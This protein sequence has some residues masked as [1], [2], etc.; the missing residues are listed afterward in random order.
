MTKEIIQELRG[1]SRSVH[2]AYPGVDDD[3][4]GEIRDVAASVGVLMLE[5]EPE[6]PREPPVDVD[7]PR[8]PPID[9]E[10]PVGDPG[11]LED[12]HAVFQPGGKFDWL[13]DQYAT[14]LIA[15][16]VPFFDE[17][18]RPD[19][20][21]YLID[22]NYGS[23]VNDVGRLSGVRILGNSRRVNGIALWWTARLYNATGLL[24]GAD[25]V[26]VG[27]FVADKEGH[28][29]VYADVHGNLHIRKTR[30]Y[31][32][33]GQSIQLIRRPANCRMSFDGYSPPPFRPGENE[34]DYNAR[35]SKSTWWK[36]QLYFQRQHTI[37]L[38]DVQSTDDGLGKSRGSNPFSLFNTGQNVVVKGMTVRC[39]HGRPL[40]DDSNKTDRR[41]RGGLMLTASYGATCRDLYLIGYDAECTRPDRPEL[42]L[43]GVDMGLVDKPR[44]L[45]LGENGLPRIAIYENCGSDGPITINAPE[46]DVEVTTHGVGS[47]MHKLLATKRL[48]AGE[49]FT[50]TK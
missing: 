45:R 33:L 40:P 14:A 36:A 4:Q 44:I 11:D 21:A 26:R 50:W 1:L 38:E 27:D 41:S 20:R 7:P 34:K 3:A 22:N 28:A 13:N 35:E 30:S 25:A 31:Q 29:I 17:L 49:S 19:P 46:F 9:V 47:R 18:R 24:D 23:T 6:P 37:T 8:E 42:M 39:A 43:N 5:E 16:G 10:P 12:E 2:E 15:D 32:S 48:K